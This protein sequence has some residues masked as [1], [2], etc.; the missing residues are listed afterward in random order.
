[1]I[2]PSIRKLYFAGLI[3]GF[4]NLIVAKSFSRDFH[5]VSWLGILIYYSIST[6]GFYSVPRG[7]KICNHFDWIDCS[8]S[9][10]LTEIP[11]NSCSPHIP[12]RIVDLASLPQRQIRW[13]TNLISSDTRNGAGTYGIQKSPFSLVSMHGNNEYK[14]YGVIWVLSQE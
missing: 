9:K 12:V 2:P 11:E 8:T 5:G 6:W 3:S 7:S 14:Y 4:G 10:V 13:R 1:M